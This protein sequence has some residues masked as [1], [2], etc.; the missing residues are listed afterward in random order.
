VNNDI[1]TIELHY[2]YAG[3]D[4]SALHQVSLTCHVGEITLIVGQNGSG[5]TTLA[6]C[7]NGLIPHSYKGGTL[8]GEVR[9]AGQPTAHLSLAQLAR[10]VGTVMQDPDRQ[11]VATRVF[12]DIAFGPENLGLPRD[13]IRARVHEVA[14]QLRITHLLDRDT[15]TLSGGE[16]QKVVIAGALA[17]RPGAL[18]LDEPLASLD[19]PSAREALAIFRR[20][21]DAGLTVV[22]IEHRLREV[23]RARPEHAVALQSGSVAFDGDIAGLRAWLNGRGACHAVAYPSRSRGEVLLAFREVVFAYPGARQPQLHGVSLEVRAGDVVALIGPN[24][25]GKSTLCKLAVGLVRPQA[26]RVLVGGRDAAHVTTAQLVRTVGYV[27]QNPAAMLFANT[28][29]EELAFGPHNLGLADSQI[30]PAIEQA[31]DLVGLAH[32]PLDQSPF[33][34]SFGQQKRVTV[35]SVLAMRPRVLILDEPTAGLDDDTAEALLA[36][37]LSM[38]GGPE[39][40]VLVTHDLMLARR[41]ANRVVLMAAGRVVADGAPED[42]LTDPKVMGQAGFD[43]LFAHDD[44]Y[45]AF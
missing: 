39:A 15:H 29:Y 31:L 3:R 25:A 20:L 14:A 1:Q 12:Y 23:L 13:E 5:K 38:P 40:I 24:G 34:L 8:R 22:M 44:L 42:I 2:T 32:L 33:S 17:M 19:P 7:I 30:A 21:A 27:F 9:C 26:G 36:R 28:L 10:R 37:L 16:L 4:V 45:S 43:P 41:F 11:I 35:A 6:R 18:L